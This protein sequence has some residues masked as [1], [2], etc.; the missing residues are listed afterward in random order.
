MVTRTAGRSTGKNSTLSAKKRVLALVDRVNGLT[1]RERAIIGV[2]LSVST[3]VLLLQLVWSSWLVDLDTL[4]KG[5]VQTENRQAAMASTLEELE[6]KLETD[7]DYAIKVQNRQ[8]AAQ[9]AAQEEEIANMLGYLVKP[10]EMVGLLH[11]VLKETGG[12]KIRKLESLPTEQVFV[13]QEEDEGEPA[14]HGEQQVRGTG[15][16]VLYG[17]L[18]SHKVRIE[19]EAGFFSTLAY[20]E[21]LESLDSGLILKRLEY[22]VNEYPEAEITLLVETIGLDKEW[23]GV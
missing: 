19:I 14:E 12:L 10:E 4:N 21:H 11:Q 20:L 23:L 18:Y 3:V 13:E 15:S 6:K 2:T 8:L 5:L 17:H 1:L 9:L 22:R 7:P 16:D